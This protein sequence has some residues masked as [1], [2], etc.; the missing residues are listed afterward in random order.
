VKL[1]C[2][3]E[4]LYRGLAIVSH[5]GTKNV[6]LPIL[7]NVLLRADGSGLKLI[8]TNLEIAITCNV[9]GKIEQQGEYTVPSKLFF[10]YVSLLPNERVDVDL[11]DDSL[12]V[13]CGRSKTKIKGISASEFPLVPPVTGGQ[14]YSVSVGD[15]KLALSQ[16]LF[17]TATNESRP[18]LS[19]VFISFGHEAA[20]KTGAVLAATDS[21][22]LAEAIVKLKA[23][24]EARRDVIVPQR[25]LAELNRIISVS[26]EDVEAPDSIEVE[27]V[28]S[29]IVFRFGGVEITSRTIEGKYPDYRQII[30]T[31]A[32]TEVTIERSALSQ[33][34][35]TVS[36]FSKTGLFDVAVTIDPKTNSMELS[37][38]DASRGENTVVL[39]GEVKGNQN[40]ITLNYRYLLDGLNAI[41]GEKVMIKVI[42][43]SNPCV[44]TPVSGS[45]KYQYI[46]MP[47]RQ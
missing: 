42:D 34:V 25:T 8:S 29:Q 5:V 24:S 10:D 7:G 1:S 47:I 20:G 19:G 39:T 2:T 17:A 12:A 6:N 3:R 43:A 22:R 44:V 21:Y 11:Y 15:L 23:P 27:V 26:K 35:K 4:N 14:K 32:S 46:I 16:V 30:P 33:A 31:M 36:L 28:D 45:D 40:K 37:A 9:R 13:S 38:N 18:E 41:G